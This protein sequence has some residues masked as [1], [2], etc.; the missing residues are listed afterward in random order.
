MRRDDTALVQS[1]S[2]ASGLVGQRVASRTR[3]Y[4]LPRHCEL[5][6]HGQIRRRESSWSG[7]MACAAAAEMVTRCPGPRALLQAADAP[8]RRQALQTG[9]LMCWPTLPQV[10][11]VHQS[12]RAFAKR[13]NVRHVLKV[14]QLLHETR[15]EVARRLL[16]NLCT[17]TVIPLIILFLRKSQGWGSCVYK[18][19]RGWPMKMLKG[20]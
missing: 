16:H 15:S 10:H 11:V 12:I 5:A 1:A 2:Q 13:A 18:C 4:P 14:L 20:F 17:C 19:E 7:A 9:I 3:A 8:L 6:S